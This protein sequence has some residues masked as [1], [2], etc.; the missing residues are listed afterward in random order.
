KNMPEDAPEKC[1]SPDAEAVARYI[2]DAFY[3][4]EAQMRGRSRPRPILEV[5]LTGLGAHDT[6]TT[7]PRTVPV[8]SSIS[9][10]KAQECSRPPRPS[11]VLRAGTARAPAAVSRCARCAIA[12]DARFDSGNA[13]RQFKSALFRKL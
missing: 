13:F 10:G 1:V 4:R 6:A 11:D 8:R 7:G 5:T 2:Y 9:G 3:S 12:K